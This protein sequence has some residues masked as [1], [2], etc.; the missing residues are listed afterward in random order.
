M[1]QTSTAKAR[2]VWDEVAPRYDRMMRSAERW[3]F[4]GGRPWISSR[5]EGEVLEV[6]VGTGVNLPCYPSGLRITG[7]DL[8]PAMLAI[9]RT[10][11]RAA[12]IDASLHEGPYRPHLTIGV[13]EWLDV[14]DA[15]DRLR[16]ALVDT[17]A[18]P[19]DFQVIGVFRRPPRRSSH[20]R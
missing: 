13:W 6:G 7:I 8:S 18:L 3:W 1:G 2:R 14:A 12:G 10:R 11:A 16:A 9:A 20:R 19:L 17:A 5:A 15:A 4:V